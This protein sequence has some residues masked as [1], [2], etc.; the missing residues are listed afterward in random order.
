MDLELSDKIVIVTGG[1]AGIGGAISRRLALEGAIPVMLDRG[2]DPGY[3]DE[4]RAIQPRAQHIAVDLTDE[5]A[6]RNAVADI[7]AGGDIY[8]LVN[9]AGA[10]DGVGLDAG[11]AAF[12]Q[13]L[14]RN[15]LHYYL[16]AHLCEPHLKANQGAIVNIASK[17][18]LTG[19]GGTSGYCAAKGA[20]LA[21]TREWAVSL[22]AHNVR[23]NAVVPA[24]VATPMYER[25][26]S[27]FDDPAAARAH[28]TAR[29]PLG[30][31]MTRPEEIA[32]TAVFLLSPRA[33]HTTGQWA[34]VDGGYTHLD[35]A[36][37]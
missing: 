19:Q 31:R 21:L 35:Q 11:I 30:H 16:M 34:V 5:A 23:V 3:V 37:T 22:A 36:A 32:D 24:E 29:I 17:T 18:A 12:K 6:C 27:S 2:N 25:W 8:G 14:E 4:L 7:A 15:L 9:N 26:L 1:L 13:S 28:I 10:N 33:A 20:T